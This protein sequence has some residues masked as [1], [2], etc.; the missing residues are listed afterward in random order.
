MNYSQIFREFTP[1][2]T[3]RMRTYD[4]ISS[5]GRIA[6]FPAQRRCLLDSVFNTLLSRSYSDVLFGAGSV[7]AE[8]ASA[9]QLS[10]VKKIDTV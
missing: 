6:W 3:A 10:C 5:Q 2:Q 4:A 7:P 1:Y 9:M 8:K